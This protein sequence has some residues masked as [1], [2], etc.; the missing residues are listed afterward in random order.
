MILEFSMPRFLCVTSPIN[1]FSADP[2]LLKSLLPLE[3]KQLQGYVLVFEK[4]K[5]S[6]MLK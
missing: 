6:L 4:N 3:K 5:Y 2:L 1:V